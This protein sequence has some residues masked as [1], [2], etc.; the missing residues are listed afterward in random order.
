MIAFLG[1]CSGFRSESARVDNRAKTVAVAE[2]R[3]FFPPGC[4]LVSTQKDELGFLFAFGCDGE[5]H[6]VFVDPAVKR[7]AF[8]KG[9]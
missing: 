3:R 6:F 9:R 7:A 4:T 5:L 2:I 1:G 8:V